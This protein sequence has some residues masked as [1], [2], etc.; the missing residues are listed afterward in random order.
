MNHDAKACVA[1]VGSM[2][3]VENAS[4]SLNSDSLWLSI[5]VTWCG[6]MAEHRYIVASKFWKLDMLLP[7]LTHPTKAQISG[8][9]SNR[10][11]H[12][13]NASKLYGRQE[14]RG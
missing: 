5:R 8:T 13:M 14:A 12:S 3:G 10:Q 7:A 9:F 2:N 11:K 4:H 1:D 6:R